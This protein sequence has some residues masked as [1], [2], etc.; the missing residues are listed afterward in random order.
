MKILVTGGAGYIG[1]HVVLQ[2]CEE[3]YEVV[4]LDNLSL[5]SKEA[6][7]KRAEFIEGSILD[8]K[9]LINSLNDV[10]AVI[11]L[12]AFKSAGESMDNPQKYSENNVIGSQRLL[13]AMIENN[14]KK[15]IFSS[16]A[17]V[18]LSLIHI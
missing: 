2:L 6:V 3:S 4:V 12:A 9:D 1:S 16:T 5:G 14:V 13:S 11:H 15:I 18:Y 17:A 10:D 8:S 7:D